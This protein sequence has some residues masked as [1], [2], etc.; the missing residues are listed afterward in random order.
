[1]NLWNSKCLIRREDITAFALFPK[2]SASLPKAVSCGDTRHQI[3][4]P[5]GRVEAQEH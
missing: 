4:R 3:S 5:R 2:F 1:M